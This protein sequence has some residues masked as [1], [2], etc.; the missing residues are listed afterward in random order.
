M[1]IPDRIVYTEV[2]IWT[3]NEEGDLW[4]TRCNEMFHFNDGTPIE[5]DFRFCP[6]CGKKLLYETK[7]P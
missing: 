7:I 1:E 3:Y 2:C 6:Y 5:N 4:D